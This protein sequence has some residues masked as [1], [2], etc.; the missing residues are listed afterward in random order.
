MF[1]NRLFLCLFSYS[2]IRYTYLGYLTELGNATVVLKINVLLLRMEMKSN[3]HL[4]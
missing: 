2:N 3:L 1:L 4:L